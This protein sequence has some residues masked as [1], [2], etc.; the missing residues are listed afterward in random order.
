MSHDLRTPLV[1]IKGFVG[2]L[3]KD[4]EENDVNRIAGDIDKINRA[5]DTMGALLNDLL[6][7]SRIGR[8]IGDRV[9]CNLTDIA[10]QAIELQT[11]IIDKAGVEITVEEM[12]TVKGDKL[13]LIEVYLNLVENAI[14]FMGDQKLPRIDIGS[15]V[16]DGETHFY[17]K[18]NGVGI[19]PEFH[20]LVFGLF[21]RLNASLEGT[22]V[23][24][25]LVKRIIE[26][27]GGIIWVESDGAGCGSTILFTLPKPG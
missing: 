18:D 12:P 13:R 7:L 8:V 11:S 24:L 19:A 2:L 22:G 25:T 20:N 17:V 9:I 26:V 23:G 6:E 16:K 21:E 5:T 27:H 1:T 14:K 3:A 15:L 4:I 10:R